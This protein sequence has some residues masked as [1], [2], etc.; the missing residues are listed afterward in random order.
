[1]PHADLQRKMAAIDIYEKEVNISQKVT[2]GTYSTAFLL[3]CLRVMNIVHLEITTRL[4]EA[5]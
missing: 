1:M 4:F 2:C 3:K 5:H